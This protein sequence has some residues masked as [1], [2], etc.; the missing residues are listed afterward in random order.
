MKRR[1]RDPRAERRVKFKALHPEKTALE[2]EELVTDSF[3]VRSEGGK[4]RQ[5]QG[6]TAG[7]TLAKR[8]GKGKPQDGAR[9][10]RTAD[11]ARD[12]IEFSE[13]LGITL[14]PGQRV[15]LKNLYGLALDGEEMELYGQMTGGLTEQ[16]GLGSEAVEGVWVLGARS[17]KSL[18]ASIIGLY[19]SIERGKRWRKHLGKHEK[20][21]CIIVATRLQQ[22]QDLIQ[23]NAAQLLLNSPEYSGWIEGEPTKTQLDL[24]NGLSLLSIPCNSTAGRGFPI[25]TLILDELGHWWT[26]GAKADVDIF[27]SLSPRLGQFPGAKTVL[28]S[29]PSAKQGLLWSWYKEG[30]AV[31]GRSTLQGSTTLLNPDIDPEFLERMKAR[32]P[33]LYDREICALFA[34]RRSAYLE[35]HLVESAIAFVTDREPAGH[36]YVLGVDQSGFAGRD[37]FAVA[38]AHKEDKRVIV[39]VVRSWPGTDST[40]ILDEVSA[41]CSRYGIGHATIDR[42]ARGWVEAELKKRGLS[43]DV[44][45]LLPQIYQ[46]GKSLML[47]GDLAIPD[48]PELKEGMLSTMAFYGRN[49][50]MSIE[51]PRTGEAGHGDLADAAMSAI[52]KASS[53]PHQEPFG[54]WARELGISYPGD[55]P[56]SLGSFDPTVE[57]Y[58]DWKNNHKARGAKSVGRI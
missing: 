22:A 23:R 5:M 18:M 26:E 20:G 29:T 54:I 1:K 24:T 25:Y 50:S 3:R 46:N 8:T 31:P 56:L 55:E 21:Y 30:F 37:R 33:D 48:H 28:L 41:L 15:V 38:V 27:N 11:K 2:I 19:E 7:N 16:H 47:A 32:D 36:H 42:Y 44:R 45:P 34:E 35:S 49:N 10:P 13:R 52:W 39:D 43:V 53:E 4:A 40:F 12:I 9:K 51:H 14:H 58:S 6:L 17:G 57:S